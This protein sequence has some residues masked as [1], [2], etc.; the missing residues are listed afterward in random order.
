MVKEFRSHGEV[1]TAVRDLDVAIAEGEFF[2]LLGPSGCG[3]TTTLRMVAGFVEPSAGRVL[4]GGR[5]VTRAPPHRRDTG[6]VWAIFAPK[7]TVTSV[8]ITMPT[9]A[10]R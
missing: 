4:I 6:M 2:Y 5:D 7:G 9:S 3:K 10:G 1:V 8:P